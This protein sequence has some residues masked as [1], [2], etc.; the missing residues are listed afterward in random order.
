MPYQR[1]LDDT[2]AGRNGISPGNPWYAFVNREA[3]GGGASLARAL[4]LA[5]SGG[6][7]PSRPHVATSTKKSLAGRMWQGIKRVPTHLFMNE[8]QGR[9]NSGVDPSNPRLAIQGA[10]P[11]SAKTTSAGADSTKYGRGV[12]Y[13]ARTDGLRAR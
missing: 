3:A 10:R 1:A 12:W 9:G 4:R 11:D 5:A 2:A 13:H 7:P 6:R 8:H